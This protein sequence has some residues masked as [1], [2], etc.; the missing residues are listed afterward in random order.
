VGKYGSKDV[1]KYVRKMKKVR[2]RGEIL[3]NE[4]FYSIFLQY[5]FTIYLFSSAT[6]K[7]DKIQDKMDGAYF[8][9]SELCIVIYICNKNL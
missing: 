4:K 8:M 7:I 6:L 3:H 9:F 2:A 1:S 5:I